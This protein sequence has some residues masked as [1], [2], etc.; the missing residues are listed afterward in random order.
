MRS[1]TTLL[2]ILSL[3][4]A[5]GANPTRGEADRWEK[6]RAHVAAALVKKA[7]PDS[8]AAAGLLSVG[9]P[10]RSADLLARAGAAAPE[11]ADLLWL[12]I[13]SCYKRPACDPGPLERRL[14]TLDPENGA[15]WLGALARAEPAHDDAA[16]DAALAAISHSTRVDIYW[17]TL[18]ARLSSAAAQTG[19]IPLREAAVSIIGVLAAQALPAYNVVSKSCKGERL[20]RVEVVQVC[21]GIARAFEHGD[22]DITAMIGIAIAKRVWPEQSSEWTAATEAR[23]AYQYRTRL[24][25][26]IDR[27]PWD[28]N[29][30]RTFLALCAANHREQDVS[31]ARLVAAGEKPDPPQ[32]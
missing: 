24:L 15:A 30:A 19:A 18:I 22:T 1:T 27:K 10:E 11:R 31:R 25:E 3:P 7:D 20:Q 28:D 9:P 32:E 4:L 8:L 2:L 23:R 16:K 6:Q 13:Q 21:R 14:R 29:A 26:R 5:A 17:T 12:Q